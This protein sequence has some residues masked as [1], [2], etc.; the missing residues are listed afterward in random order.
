VSV[1]VDT[2]A[3]VDYLNGFPSPAADAL[4][5]LLQ[6]DEDICT[7]GIV[8]AEV[9][10]G[11]RRDRE[12]TAI[13]RSFENLLFLEPSGIEVYLRAGELYRSLRKHGV[14][15]RSTV[16]CIIAVLAEEAD[17]ALLARDSDMDAILD[18]GL[19]EAE[20]WPAVATEG[21]G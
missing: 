20:R 9:F 15:V 4:A 18:S 7:C 21:E 16:D 3:W 17:C 2:S 11:L 19:L 6:G 12:R 14:T 5:D 10:Q 13:Q 1:L 8:V